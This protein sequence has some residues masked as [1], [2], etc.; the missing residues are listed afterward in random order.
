MVVSV[1]A[2]SVVNVFDVAALSAL[3][4]FT[5]DFG[6]SSTFLE[7]GSETVLIF[8]DMVGGGLGALDGSGRSIGC[9]VCCTCCGRV[10]RW[11]GIKEKAVGFSLLMVKSR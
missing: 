1:F 7:G 6:G 4:I 5:E 9:N 8:R 2:F 3:W 10:K 11:P